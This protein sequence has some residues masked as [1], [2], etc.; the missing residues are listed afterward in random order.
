V[1]D[2]G[3]LSRDDE[4]VNTKAAALEVLLLISVDYLTAQSVSVCLDSVELKESDVGGPELLRCQFRKL[5]DQLSEHSSEVQ[6]IVPNI[7]QTTIRTVASA[8]SVYGF[9]EKVTNEVCNRSTDSGGHYMT[10]AL[11]QSVTQ[12]KVLQGLEPAHGH[13][14]QQVK[15]ATPSLPALPPSMLF[16]APP[17][18]LQVLPTSHV[19]S[20]MSLSSNQEL[21]THCAG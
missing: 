6:N 10:S 4:D 3:M 11:S 12:D 16:S 9:N 21:C 17:Q 20:F 2:A 1:F 5:L 18:A 19:C 14:S 7:P 8:G 15:R 13:E